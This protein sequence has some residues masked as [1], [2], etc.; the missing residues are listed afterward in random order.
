MSDSEVD[1]Q[2]LAGMYYADGHVRFYHGGLFRR[3]LRLC[4]TPAPP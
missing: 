1:D 2:A 3:G 4:V